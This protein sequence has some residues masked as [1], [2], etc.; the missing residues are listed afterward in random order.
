M[1]EKGRE[2]EKKKKRKE[3]GEEKKRKS[4]KY[5]WEKNKEII[6]KVNIR[7]L[8]GLKNERQSMQN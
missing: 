2:G 3:K 6:M 4:G 8:D 5:E 1:R 7:C